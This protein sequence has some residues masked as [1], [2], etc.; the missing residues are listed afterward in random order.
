MDSHENRSNPLSNANMLLNDVR[1]INRA[2]TALS[3]RPHEFQPGPFEITV[4]AD[5]LPEAQQRHNE[6]SIAQAERA[7]EHASAWHDNLMRSA[8]FAAGRQDQAN[9]LLWEI[10]EQNAQALTYLGVLVQVSAEATLQLTY[11]GDVLNS[12]N[13]QLIDMEKSAARRHGEL[14]ALIRTP[15]L[16]EADER[17]L[18]A[19]EHFALQNYGLCLD[20]LRRVFDCRSTHVPAWLLFGRLSANR[21]QPAV[22]K[23][24]FRRAADHAMQQENIDGY[25]TAMIRLS[26]LER[27]VGNFVDAHKVMV[28]ACKG[29]PTSSPLLPKAKY[30]ELKARI[31]V[32]EHRNATTGSEIARELQMLF[33]VLPDLRAEVE[34]SP[35]FALCREHC[36]WLESGPYSALYDSCCQLLP[37]AERSWNETWKHHSHHRFGSAFV[38]ILRVITRVLEEHEY[39]KTGDERTQRLLSDAKALVARLHRSSQQIGL[40]E[41]VVLRQNGLLIRFLE[42]KIGLYGYF[43]ADP[44]RAELSEEEFSSVERLIEYMA[45]QAFHSGEQDDMSREIETSVLFTEYRTTRNAKKLLLIRKIETI[46]ARHLEAEAAK[47]AAESEAVQLAEQVRLQREWASNSAQVSLGFVQFFMVIAMFAMFCCAGIAIR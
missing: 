9:D 17:F 7:F 43:R 2:V 22:A 3:L 24:S 12:V 27:L 26:H 44:S 42:L 4:I 30:E 1:G 45:A 32:P 37:R 38:Q 47:L 34:T 18:E 36:R 29:V 16:V 21:G 39:G 15:L 20:K 33:E 10:S 41:A 11:M 35:L 25:V 23:A 13:G 5:A 28:E 19:H 31:A 8:E 40:D 6:I 14:I 46:I